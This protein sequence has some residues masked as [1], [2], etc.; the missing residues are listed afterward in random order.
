MMSR[1]K[2]RLV[3]SPEAGQKY[4]NVSSKSAKTTIMSIQLY[5]AALSEDNLLFQNKKRL[6]RINR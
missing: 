4:P 5:T 3:L 6:D 2:A 1:K